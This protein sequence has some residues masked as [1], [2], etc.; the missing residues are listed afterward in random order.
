MSSRDGL[1]T[2]IFIFAIS[3]TSFSVIGV[4]NFIYGAHFALPT[5]TP[6]FFMS[7]NSGTGHNG[8][9]S[10]RRQQN[11]DTSKQRQTKTARQMLSQLRQVK[12]KRRQ[13]LVKT[14]TSIVKN[15]EEFLSKRRQSVVKTATVSKEVSKMFISS[16][17]ARL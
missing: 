13:P 9:T 8:D 3:F 4:A 17:A 1:E 16:Q 2:S 11:G 6:A 5:H 14:A 12:S 15:G 10:E 7:E